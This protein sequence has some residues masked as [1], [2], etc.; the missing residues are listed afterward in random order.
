M[1]IAQ[2]DIRYTRYEIVLR[3]FL[4]NFFNMLY[5]RCSSLIL[6]QRLPRRPEDLQDFAITGKNVR[7]WNIYISRE[8]TMPIIKSSKKRMIQNKKKRARNKE[9]K[10]RTKTSIKKLEALV[11]DKKSKEAKD[12]LRGVIS[13]IDKAASKGVWHKNKASREKSKLMKKLG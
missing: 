11:Q 13:L 7:G 9:I 5:F 2:Y 1:R 8:L 3:Y 10:K 4:Q 12:S 6:H